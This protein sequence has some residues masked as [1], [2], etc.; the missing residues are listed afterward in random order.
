MILDA[1]TE[2]SSAQV[3]GTGATL[4]SFSVD[5]K[6]AVRNGEVQFVVNISGVSGTGPTLAIEVIGADDAGLTSGVVPLGRLDPVVAA[7]AAA[8]NVYVKANYTTKKR[9]LGLR[10]TMGGTTPAATV[11]AS[12]SERVQ[13][14]YSQP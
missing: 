4:S 10:Y 11:T 9:Y 3:L 1:L 14:D 2:V 6:A 8:K 7:A 13:G 5:E 12:V